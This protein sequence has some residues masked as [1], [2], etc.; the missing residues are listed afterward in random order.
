[1]IKLVLDTIFHLISSC[2]QEKE[3]ETERQRL[4]EY[5]AHAEMNISP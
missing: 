2:T 5:R 1:M 4:Q 3:E